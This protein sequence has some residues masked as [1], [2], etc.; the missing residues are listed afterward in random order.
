[1][2]DSYRKRRRMYA[3]GVHKMPISVV[4][5]LSDELDARLYG[6]PLVYMNKE[7]VTISDIGDLI[8]LND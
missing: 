6:K 1:M 8:N 2:P 4:L 7:I 5:D 3:Y